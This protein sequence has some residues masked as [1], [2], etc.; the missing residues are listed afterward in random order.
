MCFQNFTQLSP[1]RLR[2]WHAVSM[3]EFILT[4]SIVCIFL[5]LIGDMINKRITL[6]NN[7]SIKNVVLA[8]NGGI[9]HLT[10]TIRCAADLNSFYYVHYCRLPKKDTSLA[11]I[12]QILQLQHLRFHLSFFQWLI[13]LNYFDLEYVMQNI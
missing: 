9:H 10:A 3:V 2:W 13:H 7:Q 11:L 5:A 1:F 8:Y 12:Q 4:S 6:R